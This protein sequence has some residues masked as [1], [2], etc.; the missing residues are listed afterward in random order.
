M[1]W[2]NCADCCNSCDYHNFSYSKKEEIKKINKEDD[3]DILV[4]GVIDLFFIDKDDKLILVD[5]KTDYVQNENE[6]VE[7]YKGQLDLYKEALEQ[8]LNKKVDKMCIYSVY[9]NKLIEIWIW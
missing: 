9:L 1:G 7:E 4:Q 3:E 6:L 2:C 8:S 5:Y